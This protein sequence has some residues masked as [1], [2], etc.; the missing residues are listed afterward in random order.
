MLLLPLIQH[1]QARPR[2]AVPAASGCSSEATMIESGDGSG[3]DG[4][5]SITLDVGDWPRPAA[6]WKRARSWVY[7]ALFVR[8]QYLYLE[9]QSSRVRREA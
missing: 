8:E 6:L 5:S 1:T 3:G 4:S 2:P 7:I 9:N